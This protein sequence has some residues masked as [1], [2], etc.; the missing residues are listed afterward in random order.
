MLR[1]FALYVATYHYIYCMQ[2]GKI[3]QHP[4]SHDH[5]TDTTSCRLSRNLVGHRHSISS[6]FVLAAHVE[7]QLQ[8]S[9]SVNAMTFRSF[10]ARRRPVSV[11]G[12]SL[13]FLAFGSALVPAPFADRIRAPER[14]SAGGEP[15]PDLQEMLRCQALPLA[16]LSWFTGLLAI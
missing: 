6:V 1:R 16:A 10:R 12:A 14:G 13:T 8:A 7:R 5:A 15:A 11:L 2:N 9:S 3:F 4:F